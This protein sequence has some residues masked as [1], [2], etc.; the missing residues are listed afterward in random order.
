[1]SVTG[2]SSR[3]W[4][5]RC[6]ASR[7]GRADRRTVTL[8]MAEAAP[9][10][11]PA[12]EQSAPAAAAEDDTRQRSLPS[13]PDDLERRIA[14]MELVDAP[15]PC[16]RAAPAR[17]WSWPGSA[18]RMRCDSCWPVF[19]RISTA[20]PDQAAPGRRSPR[21]SGAADAAG[22]RI[23]GAPGRGRRHAGGRQGLHPAGG[24]GRDRARMACG[25]SRTATCSPACRR[26]QRRGP[27]QRQRPGRC[28]R[29]A[30]LG[31]GRCTG[32]RADA[33]RLLRRHGGRSA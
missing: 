31:G 29:R 15:T 4:Q 8:A 1:M 17:C 23:A 13:R 19:R 21:Q 2:R 33:R 10:K 16:R 22:D 14:S 18:A 9:P 12:H 32:R 3:H 20:G 25:S 28:R 6:R 5:P 27:A 24:A 11:S 26:R 7:P 30:G